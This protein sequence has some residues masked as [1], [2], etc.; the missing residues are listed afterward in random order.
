MIS[1]RLGH[2]L[3]DQKR[4]EV[5]VIYNEDVALTGVFGDAIATAGARDTWFAVEQG[6][7]ERAFARVKIELAA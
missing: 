7:T 4:K 3:D 6:L 1:A 5:M 2:L